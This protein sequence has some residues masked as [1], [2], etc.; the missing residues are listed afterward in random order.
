MTG[1]GAVTVAVPAHGD[2]PSVQRLLAALDAQAVHRDG[3]LPTIVS[4]DGSDPAL[5]P[6]LEAGAYPAL[7][8]VVVRSEANGGP[9]A[10]RNRALAAVRT[11]F[12]AFL[13][14]DMV[15]AP[16][17]VARL[18]MITGGGNG[19]DAAEGRVTAAAATPFT[20]TTVVEQAGDRH[21]GGNVVFRTD[22]LR[23]LDGYDERYFDARRRLH[24]REDA[25]LYFRL[26]RAGVTVEFDEQL[27]AEHPPLES[28][29]WRTIRLARRYHFDPLL[30][31]DFPTE[32]AAMH[33]ADRVGPLT[34]RRAR[35]VAAVTVV[36]GT[37]VA[38]VSVLGGLIPLAVVG[39]VVAATGW[40][41]TGMALCR[42]RTVRARDVP[43]LAVVA[44]V[45]PW[46]YLWHYYR[47]VVAF[48]HRPRL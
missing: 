31:R 12:V 36:M 20:H 25:D 18:D 43:A 28:S 44:A 4:D 5:G 46:V 29:L 27:R 48:R 39:A 23:S 2:A 21:I 19:P 35:H 42:G 8:L 1:A 6:A 40:L 22:L 15:P 26:R 7:D 13:D 47:G 37:A 3:R 16:G 45:I 17:W 24:F 32:F 41:A 10:A 9:G 11:P 34:A 30:S 14:A 33:T 38:L